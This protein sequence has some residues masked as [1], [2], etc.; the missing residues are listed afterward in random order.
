ML[1]NWISAK[2]AIQAMRAVQALCCSDPVLFR[3]TLCAMLRCV[4]CVSVWT[5]F[6]SFMFALPLSTAFHNH[7]RGHSKVIWVLPVSHVVRNINIS[8]LFLPISFVLF[9]NC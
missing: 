1:H 5:E 2:C 3:Q 8:L 4:S 6:I 9:L 7:H